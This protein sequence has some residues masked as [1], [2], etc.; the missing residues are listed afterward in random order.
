MVRKWQVLLAFIILGMVAG[1]G[2]ARFEEES[3][4]AR[5]LV[6]FGASWVD[7]DDSSP[8]NSMQATESFSEKM[9]GMIKG[10]WFDEK[11]DSL[12]GF[13]ADCGVNT[14]EKG[15]LLLSCETDT[16]AK[17]QALATESFVVLDN[18]LSDYNTATGENYT[19]GHI[20]KQAVETTPTNAKLMLMLVGLALIIGI[21]WVVL[22]A[23]LRGKIWN[24]SQAEEL[25][26]KEIP[27]LSADD[28][29]HLPGANLY[30]L[31]ISQLP[32]N[33]KKSNLFLQKFARFN[34]EKDFVVVV[35]ERTK[36]DDL[37]FAKN[38]APGAKLIAVRLKK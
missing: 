1:S 5:V 11:L 23:F 14:Y 27:L 6:S 4:E 37:K 25:F 15:N 16:L 8:Y 18:V 21:I 35:L 19:F 30:F 22:C 33:F 17:A 26:G 24:V 34:V 29:A 3:Y 13:D 36:F 9:M 32:N 31:G 2:L 10:G 12:A 7:G 38:I 28:L 20:S